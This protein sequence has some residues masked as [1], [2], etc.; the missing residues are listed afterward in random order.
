M[1]TR[2][3]YL[4]GLMIISGIIL[5]VICYKGLG[6]DDQVPLLTT[7]KQYFSEP[8]PAQNKG[9]AADDVGDASDLPPVTI[10]EDLIDISFSPGIDISG[11]DEFED[12]ILQQVIQEHLPNADDT[13]DFTAFGS[14]FMLAVVNFM[15]SGDKSELTTSLSNIVDEST[16][17]SLEQ[18][19][20][21]S[22][23]FNWK[24]IQPDKCA[25]RYYAPGK[26]ELREDIASQIEGVILVGQS[27][28]SPSI[29]VVCSAT[30]ADAQTNQISL[31]T[32]MDPETGLIHLVNVRALKF[33]ARSMKLN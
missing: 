5:S 3:I 10:Q 16:L 21:S 20:D 18:L 32:T 13:N 4:G 1:P 6:Q 11:E 2:T 15:W 28:P 27:V 7:D 9:N 23:T 8:K 25:I 17:H 30:G 19:R 29:Q 12:L 14:S 33:H 31:S 22:T 26:Y 24:K